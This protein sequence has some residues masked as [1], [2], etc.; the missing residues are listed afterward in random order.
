LE[1]RRALNQEILDGLSQSPVTLTGDPVEPEALHLRRVSVTGTFENEEGVALR[2]RS[3]QGRPGAE[4]LVPL[5]IKNSDKAVLV[6]RGWVPLQLATQEEQLA[7]ALEGEVTV[8]GVAYRSQ[9]RP[10]GFLVPTDPTPQP[11][12]RLDAWFRADIDRIQQQ[13]AEPLLPIFVRQSAT[14]AG[15]TEPPLPQPEP[16]LTEGSHLGYA[17]QWFSFALILVVMYSAFVWQEYKR[18][19]QEQ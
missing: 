9:P 11:G 4:L 5:R 15:A 18:K 2:N 6:N 10:D 19:L 13:V 12:K 14:P 7:Y 1:Q 3:Y 16:E 17:V 8:E